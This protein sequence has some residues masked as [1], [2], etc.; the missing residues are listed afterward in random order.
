MMQSLRDGAQSTTAKVLTGLIILSFAGFGLDSILPGGSGTSVAEVNGTEIS[1]VE[2]QRAIDAQ[3]RQLMQIFGERLDPAML[4]DE[5]LRPGA[6]ESVI[7]RQLFMQQASALELVASEKEIGRTV[8]AIEAFQVEG[9]FSPEQYKVVLANAGLSPERFR[10]S[11]AQDIVL[12]QLQDA[13]VRSEFTTPTELAAAAN[14]QAEERDVRYLL[15]DETAVASSLGVS[16]ADVAEFFAQNQHRFVSEAAVTVDYLEL[17]L[18]DFFEPVPEAVLLEQF[19]TVKDEYQVAEQARVAHILLMQGDDEDDADYQSRINDVAA[20]LAAGEDFAA[21]AAN[22]SDDVG[23]ANFGGELGFTDGSAFP[24]PM[25]A[26][27]AE[28]AVGAVSAPVVT[29]AGTHFI[30]VEERVAAESADFDALREELA[31]SIQESNAQQALLSAVETLRDV[32]FNAPDLAGPSKLV[33]VDVKQATPVT[34]SSGTGVF[35]Q[36]RLRT[37]VFAD[38]VYLAGN[39]S[40][41]IELNS[42]HFIA[43]RVAAKIPPAQLPLAEVANDIRAELESNAL[44]LALA[45]LTES[46]QAQL[47]AGE[48]IESMAKAGGYEWRVELAA[49]RNNTMLPR[50]VLNTAFSMPVSAPKLLSPVALPGNQ[51]ALVQLARV[52]PGDIAALGNQDVAQLSQETASSAQQIAFLEFREALRNNAEIVTR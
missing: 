14:V 15:I 26:A 39:N 5:R 31:K 16:E 33:G 20:R 44:S 34:R 17:T 40:E 18:E 24:D 21:L 32:A 19:E 45:S 11:Q 2:L 35:A 50:E 27:I 22:A 7:Q 49:R 38:E 10:R 43:V 42:G 25:E 3:K 48:S 4:E 28:L 41:V 1:P 8:T 9:K 46:L 23:S 6:L 47:L 36:P 51:L 30:R 37:A 29:D 13:I 12:N 52:R